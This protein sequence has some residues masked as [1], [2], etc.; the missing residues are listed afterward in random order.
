[1]A[2]IISSSIATGES[3]RIMVYS[4]DTFGLGNIR[5]MLAICKHL[6]KSIPNLSIFLISGSPMLHSFRL[7]RGLDYLKLPC[8]NRGESGEVAVKYLDAD[9][10]STLKL[11]SELI[12]AAAKYY[13]PDLLLV[14]K[15]PPGIKGELNSTIDY[16]KSSLPKTKLVLLLR[17]ILD[18]PEK[19][20]REWQKENYY[21]KV[22][23]VFDHVLV[24]GM[25]EIFD[26]CKEYQ[27]NDAIVSKVSFCGYIRKESGLKNRRTIRQ[28][29]GIKLEEK[30]VLVTPGGGED[31]YQL[32]DTY[33][34]AW[35]K[36]QDAVQTQKIRSLIFCGSEMPTEQQ[37]Q[38]YQKAEKFP[39]VTVLEFTDDL[40][41][42]V[43]TANTVV[44]M[45]GYNTITEVLQKGKKAI[46]LPRIKPGKE[47]LIRAQSMAKVGLIKMIHPDELNPNLL[48]ETLLASFK[49][50]N[51]HNPIPHLDFGGIPRLSDHLAMLLFSSFNLEMPK[52][53]AIKYT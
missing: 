7:P 16:L 1:M 26:V 21:Q 6:L 31:G 39:E 48:G 10:D 46:V 51:N 11:R 43:N 13:Q 38:I 2:R 41:S 34:T 27:F 40:M 35:E 50:T 36:I 47:Q 19:T 44:S 52:S 12:L 45:C 33:L 29:L 25:P 18:T 30:L 22:E 15:K 49:R 17:D 4:H 20:I 8:L 9:I 3:K 53:L 42:Y 32:I 14:D 28:E 5:R 24:V 23:S 37:R